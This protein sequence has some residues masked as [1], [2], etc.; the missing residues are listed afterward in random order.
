MHTIFNKRKS[1]TKEVLAILHGTKIWSVSNIRSILFT[2]W[3]VLTL[4]LLSLLLSPL[5]LSFFLSLILF[6]SM[7]QYIS[8]PL[9]FT[10]FVY[11]LHLRLSSLWCSFF[12]LVLL[13]KQLFV[14]CCCMLGNFQYRTTRV[15]VCFIL[16]RYIF[17][18][19]FDI[20]FTSNTKYSF[21]DYICE[22]LYFF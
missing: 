1:P 12:P 20:F 19:L 5:S 2:P 15:R 17:N 13:T 18:Q 8:V 3:N 9:W 21:F 7:L 4:F 22:Q 10:Y 11:I 16:L 14:L 6:H